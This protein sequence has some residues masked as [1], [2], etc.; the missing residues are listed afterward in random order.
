MYKIFSILLALWVAIFFQHDLDEKKVQFNSRKIE[1]NAFKV[2]E[3]LLYD[4]KYQFIKVGEAEISLSEIVEYNGRKCY[5]A[6][7]RV[8]SL[9]FFSV[10]YKVD[11]RYESLIDVEGIYP[12]RFEQR[13]R[14]GG[15]KRD[16]YAEFD[17]VNLIAKT[18]EGVYPIPQYA[19]DVF[20]AFY[21]ARTQDYSN[22]KVGDR[23]RLENFYRNKTYP[24]EIKYLGEQIVKVKAGKF[25]CVVVEPLIVE[26]G[27]FKAKGR[28]FLW[29]TN[30]DKKIP[31]K[32]TAEIP[33]G[34]VSGE[35]R[36][37]E[38][39]EKIDAKIE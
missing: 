3:R 39:I 28:F 2:G 1:H 27:L 23:V 32:M 21:Y 5:R 6:V 8:W 38:N 12:W 10:F 35:L 15:Y 37:I 34:N 33:I 7:F 20:S 26:G 11:D 16:F 24:L 4:V 19:Q 14:E 22:K 18:S 36:E 17:H 29:I 30:D 25:K 13:I 31:V 9:P